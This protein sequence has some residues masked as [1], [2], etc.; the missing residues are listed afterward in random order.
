MNIAIALTGRSHLLNLAKYLV[1]LGHNVTFYTCVPKSRCAKFGLDKKYVKSFFPLWWWL[2]I[3]RYIKNDNLRYR[4][5]HILDRLV[6]WST[7]I[8][9][10]RCDIF[11]GSS[12]ATYKSMRKA[13]TKFNA[14]IICDCGTKHVLEQSKQ[15]EGLPGYK[16]PSGYVVNQELEN[17]DYA[18]FI[19][20]ASYKAQE[21]FIIQGIDSSKL[22]RNPYGAN[23]GMFKPTIKSKEKNIYD[24]LFV[25]TWRYLK[26]VDI[27][28]EAC[29]HLGLTLLHVG[30]Y[31][32]G[33]PFP[34]GKWFKHIDAVDETR[35]PDYYSMAKVFALPSRSDGLGL[36]LI[37]AAASGLPIVYSKDTGGRDIKELCSPDSLYMIEMGNYSVEALERALMIG[38]EMY[39]EMPENEPRSY[40]PKT[41]L[42]N[43]S[44]ESYGRRYNDFLEKIFK[45]KISQNV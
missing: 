43:I 22:F 17:Y 4:L 20:I 33:C 12:I 41:N 13:R 6:D 42:T 21:S 23:L 25:G 36:V 26:G 34:I 30:P 14:I 44:W 9:L 38:L 31:V 35:L 2:F 24:I 19:T 16:R 28:I 18:D 27:L 32:S 45:L 37:Q 1:S 8:T 29:L 11:I 15:L 10:K 7:S 40:I 39:D 5:V 3:Y